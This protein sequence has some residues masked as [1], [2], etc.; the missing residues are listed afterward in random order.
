M[1]APLGLSLDILDWPPAP[2]APPP[3]VTRQVSQG[4]ATD[5]ATRT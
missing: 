2:H 1:G 5:L 4:G 3:G